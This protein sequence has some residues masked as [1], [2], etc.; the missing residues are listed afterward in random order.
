MTQQEI[1][2]AFY[3][4]QGGLCAVCEKEVDLSDTKRTVLDH[5]HRTNKVRGLVHM[6]PCNAHVGI[7]E[8]PLAV[9]VRRYLAEHEPAVDVLYSRKAKA[10]RTFPAVTPTRSLSEA[11][12]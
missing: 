7:H 6:F 11:W 2:E 4:A 8:G 9:Q 1:R 12:A 5:D 3:Q 10:P